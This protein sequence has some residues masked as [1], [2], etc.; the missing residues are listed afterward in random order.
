MQPDGFERIPGEAAVPGAAASS[1]RRRLTVVM[2]ILLWYA[3]SVFMTLFN[4]WLFTFHGAKFPLTLTSLHFAIKTP[5]ARLAMR[6]CGIP[7]LSLCGGRGLGWLVATGFATAADV[8]LSNLSL[9]FITVSLYT[10]A[11]SSSPL[12]IL[13]I[14]IWLG[15]QKPHARLLLV[16]LA[17]AAGIALA[18]S[19]TYDGGDDD[20]TTTPAP[21]AVTELP[22]TPPAAAARR[23]LRAMRLLSSVVV[24]PADMSAGMQR[25]VGIALVLAA[26]V[27]S[28]FRWA[29]SQAILSARTVVD[30]RSGADESTAAH[31]EAGRMPRAPPLPP[32][33]LHPFALVYGTAPFGLLLL[34]PVAVLIE[35]EPLGRYLSAADA[36]ELPALLCFSSVGGFIS[37]AMLVVELRV[38]ALSSGIT[39]SVAGIFKE[40]LTVAGSAL[41]LGDVL[42]PRSVAGLALCTVGIGM[43]TWIRQ[44]EESEDAEAQAAAAQSRPQS[45]RAQGEVE[46]K[47]A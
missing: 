32:Q 19:A 31:R 28:G 22:V 39:L 21:L 29:F 3:S 41:V 5:I 30:A 40:L 1:L 35:A 43:Y 13:F 11:K 36:S 42:P 20:A 46:L 38:V 44:Q 7:P 24:V 25:L 37:F 33:S 6:A 26:S 10:I 23:M 14:S 9:L 4:K 34:V 16:L 45:P 47:P 17:I 12:W 27:L 2:Y 18:S 15:L 8:A